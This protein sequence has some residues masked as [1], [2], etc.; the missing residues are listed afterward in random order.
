MLLDVLVVHLLSDK[1]KHKYRKSLLNADIIITQYINDDYPC[2]F[3]T[4]KCLKHEFGSKVVTIAN[5]FYKGQF[6]EWV[7][8]RDANRKPIIG[9]M[10]EYHN[11]DVINA[12]VNN[13]PIQQVIERL[14]S[15]NYNDKYSGSQTIALDSLISRESSVD[16]PISDFISLNS[17][18]E[19]F[20]TFN[21]PKNILLIEYCKRIFR[22]LDIGWVDVFFDKEF[23]DKVILPTNVRFGGKIERKYVVESIALSEEAFLRRAYECYDNYKE[24]IQAFVEMNELK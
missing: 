23:L 4:T 17:R 3:V 15:I 22:Y 14:S 20:W 6:P 16:I 13:V 24:D 11:L 9:P 5:A 7:Y 21:H 19:L 18:D 8:L 1:D 2:H 10:L 12:W